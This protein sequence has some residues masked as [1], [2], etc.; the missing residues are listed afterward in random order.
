VGAGRGPSLLVEMVE[1]VMLLVISP[2]LGVV[3][4]LSGLP[5]VIHV[6]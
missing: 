5:H 3:L 1:V 6:H 2:E 4:R